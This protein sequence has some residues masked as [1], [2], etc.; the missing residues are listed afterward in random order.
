M[1]FTIILSIIGIHLPGGQICPNSNSYHMVETMDD[2]TLINFIHQSVF[3]KM[4]FLEEHGIVETHTCSIMFSDDIIGWEFF[5]FHAT[6]PDI[7]Q[8]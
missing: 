1:I 3:S 2:N 4:F 7:L 5:P 8:L 6:E